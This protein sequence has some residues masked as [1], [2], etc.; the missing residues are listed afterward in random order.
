MAIPTRHSDPTHVIAGART[1]FVTSSIAGKRSLLQ[2]DRSA[3]LFLRVL[4]DYRELGK[5]RLHEFVVMSDPLSSF[6]DGRM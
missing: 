4:Y 5:F 3:T 2:S 1:F 6:A